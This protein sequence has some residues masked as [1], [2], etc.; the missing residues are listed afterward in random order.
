MREPKQKLGKKVKTTIDIESPALSAEKRVIE[1]AHTRFEA[2]ES[3]W[4][5]YHAE[6]EKTIQFV[7]GDQ[8]DYQLK[9]NRENA[10][11]P[12][13][14]LNRIPAFLHQ[15]TNEMR[16]NTPSIQVDPVDDNASQGLAQM[17]ADHCRGIEQDSRAEAAYDTAGWFAATIGIG[18]VVVRSEYLPGS[19]KQ[20]LVIKGIE[21]PA[22]VYLDPYHKEPDGSD[23]NF[24]FIVT[25]MSKDEYIKR[26]GSSGLAQKLQI[27]SFSGSNAYKN[28]KWVTDDMVMIAEY[29]FK[30]DYEDTLYLS[31]ELSTG[32]IKETNEKPGEGFEEMDS[33]QEQKCRIRWVR[34]NDDEILDETTWPGHHI[35]VVPFK[36]NEI[37]YDGHRSVKGMAQDLRDPQRALNY[38]FSIQAQLVQ[39][40][41]QA[42]Y[43]GTIEQFDGHEHLWRDANVAPTAYLPYNNVAGVPP[44]ARDVAEVPIQ[45]SL[46]L[47]AQ[48]VDNMKGITGIRDPAIDDAHT[49]ESGKAMIVRDNQNK[50]SNYHFM[51]NQRRSVAHI[52]R[53]LLEAS[54][55]F[56]SEP[57]RSVNL[58]K[59]NGDRYTGKFNEDADTMLDKD[60]K[61]NVIIEAGPTYSTKRQEGADSMLTFIQADPN[62]FP[63]LGDI[64]LSNCDWPGAKEAAKRMRAMVPAPAL[65]ASE[66]INPKDAPALVTALK[67][68][69]GSLQQSLQKEQTDT[70]P[71]KEKNGELAAKLMF[72]EH[73]QTFKTMEMKQKHEYEIAKLQMESDK[74]ILH[75]EIERAKLKLDERRLRI[76][77]KRLGLDAI[78]VQ[79]DIASDMM[80]HG[81]KHF[82]AL[83]PEEK[84]AA[85]VKES[86]ERDIKE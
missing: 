85:D 70:L 49:P 73:D 28:G 25:S 38:F 84:E 18:F 37:W 15:V 53:I 21:D 69:V 7:E 76:E 23:M 16:Q 44:P 65:M 9:Q 61:W 3:H 35:P 68:Q 58:V 27:K 26:F 4:A 79:A 78:E 74:E 57:S 75:A 45:A 20:K 8:W 64:L 32:I 2:C 60:Q 36:G 80:E 72:S 52:G 6:A 10:G 30:E 56:Y 41:P 59:E 55:H 24:C 11:Y 81:H 71:L 5:D 14:T 54:P 43:I 42:P 86:V 63:L 51:D 34:M 17:L 77:E 40:A 82:D 66:E 19:F 13:L 1:E 67:A 46:E 48:A 47:C 33:R 62:L 22:T 12:A 83:K 31:R 50:T 39:L 29:Y